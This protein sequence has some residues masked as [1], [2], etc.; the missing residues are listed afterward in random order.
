[1]GT[2][3][4]YLAQAYYI[5]LT[6]YFIKNSSL[7]RDQFLPLIFVTI[8]SHHTAN[9]PFNPFGYIDAHTSYGFLQQYIDYLFFNNLDNSRCSHEIPLPYP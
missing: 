7:H 5:L 6:K 4:K 8:K 9:P 3:A 2:V 1:M